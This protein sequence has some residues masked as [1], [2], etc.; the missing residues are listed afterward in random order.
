MNYFD[1]EIEIRKKGIFFTPLPFAQKALEYIEKILGK[2]WWKSGEY[3]LWDMAAGTGNLQYHLPVESLKYCYL[4]TIYKE[5]IEHCVRLFPDAN[6]FQYDYLNDDVENLFPNGNINFTYQWKLPEKLRKDLQNPQIKWMIFIN[7]PYATASKGGARGSNKQ[8]VADTN[9][10]KIMHNHN[11]G[12]VS[13][14]LFS[15]F[16]Y[17]IKKEFENKTTYLGL[18]AP[19]KYISSHNDQKF[20]D[21]I[22]Q[23]SFEK[24][25]LFSSVNFSGTSRGN[26]F[27]IG[28]IIWNLHKTKKLEEQIIKLDLF[29]EN[30]E[31]IGTKIIRSIRR[32]NFLNKWIKRPPATLKFPPAGSAITVKSNNKDTRDRIAKGF[33]GSLM[34]GGNDMQHQ[35]KTFILSMPQVSAGAFSITPDNFEKAMVIY[36][37]RKIPK[38]SWITHADQFFQPISEPS[39][40]FMYDCVI[41]SIFHRSNQTVALRNVSYEG[42]IYQI[43]NHFFPF[44][45]QEIKKW[46]CTDS[47]V[48]ISMAND[49]DRFLAKWLLNK[50]L[51]QESRAVLNKGKE[52]YRVY[53]ENLNQLRTPKFKIETWD[54]GWWQIRNSLNDLSMAKELFEELKIVHNLLKDKSLP[55]IYDYGFI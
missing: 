1:N 45:L 33:L 54:A 18:F 20:R 6:C 17:R 49:A 48:A 26:Q 25:F 2:V 30:V 3:R 5:D 39:N 4:S 32:E 21:K 51:S 46:H 42:E 10:R 29:D 23:F 16:L 41:W 12:E 9:M 22:F 44:L 8:N 53:F 47:E 35:G 14:E 15:Q 7:P 43:H 38:D 27:P 11:F 40:E 37:V 24:G 55:Q 28:F 34:C 50:Q 36:A 31:K 52:I 19:P 13:R